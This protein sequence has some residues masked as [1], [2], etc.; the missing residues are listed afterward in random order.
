[1]NQP[2][3]VN[4]ALEGNFSHTLGRRAFPANSLAVHLLIFPKQLQHC[5]KSAVRLR[6][7]REIAA[8]K[9]GVIKG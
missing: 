7:I 2:I 1:V 9:G 5:G 3:A 6:L 8:V 4:W